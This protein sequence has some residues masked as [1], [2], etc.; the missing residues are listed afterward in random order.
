MAYAR[1]LTRLHG[2]ET[3]ERSRGYDGLGILLVVLGGLFLLQNFGFLDGT[4]AFIWALLFGCG[5]LVFLAVFLANRENWWAL[6]PGF[7]L[8]GLAGTMVLG[9]FDA[10]GGATGGFFL[11]SIGFAFLVIYLIRREHWWA[12]IPAGVLLTLAL[13][14]TLSSVLPGETDASLFF[15]GLAATFGALYLLPT[16]LD[17]PTWALIPAG[18]MGIIGLLLLVAGGNMVGLV[19]PFILIASGG[20]IVLRALRRS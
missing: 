19:I 4:G 15:F 11:T 18:I 6:I 3:M 1:T 16:P 14:A 2:D 17:R 9:Q 8:L 7:T 20:I 13:I 12:I 5:G 10:T